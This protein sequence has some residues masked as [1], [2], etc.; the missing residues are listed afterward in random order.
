MTTKT[1]WDWS[2]WTQSSPAHRRVLE[3]LTLD[4]QNSP[5]SVQELLQAIAAVETGQQPQYTR[6]GNA[7]YV[8]ISLEQVSIENL[9]IDDESV[10]AIPLDEFKGAVLAWSCRNP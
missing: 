3:F 5:E 10:E 7:Y 9:L 8:Q 6:S 4:L 1:P 2:V